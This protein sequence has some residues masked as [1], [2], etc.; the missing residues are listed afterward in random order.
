L[1]NI[2][3]LGQ[4]DHQLILSTLVGVVRSQFAAQATGFATHDRIRPRIEVRLTV[5]NSQGDGI[6][7]ELVRFPG[8][9]GFYREP[10]KAGHAV[11]FLEFAAT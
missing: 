1:S 6:L 7:F 2:A 4:L 8:Q 3:T 11:R 5:E 10:K 9:R